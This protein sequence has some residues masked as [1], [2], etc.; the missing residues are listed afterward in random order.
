MINKPLSFDDWKASIAPSFNDEMLKSLNRLHEV[1][2]RKEFNEM[3]DREYKEYLA[4][5][6]GNWLL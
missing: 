5:F 2:Y 4:D 1:D 3:L 6:N